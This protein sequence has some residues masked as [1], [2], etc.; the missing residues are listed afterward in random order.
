MKKYILIAL[1]LLLLIIKIVNNTTSIKVNTISIQSGKLIDDQKLTILQISDVHNRKLAGKYERILEL[2]PDLIVLT[3]DLIDRTT[4]D[5]THTI[6]LLGQLKTMDCPI[7]FVPGNH[8][9]ESPIFQSLREH[10]ADYGVIELYNRH[11]VIQM[12]GLEFNLVGVANHSTG[13]INLTLALQGVD[14]AK[15]TILLS[16]SP[17]IS[18]ERFDLI[19]SGHTHGGQV[20]LPFIGALVAPEQGFFPTY[21][22]G[23]Y[24]L[25]SGTPLYIDS[26]LGTSFLPIR[27]LNEAQVTMVNISSNKVE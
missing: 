25:D 18:E 14:F 19:L 23:L 6:K 7:Y 20:R 5:L 11:E 17:F 21:D 9:H 4:T 13:H 1:V 27:F 26:G 3:G 22:K 2:D 8:E 10:L 24:Q 12:D 16:H 15:P